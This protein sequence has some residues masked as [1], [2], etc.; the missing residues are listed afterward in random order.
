MNLK[1]GA[2]WSLVTNHQS[3]AKYF[4]KVLKENHSAWSSCTRILDS[5]KINLKEM[6]KSLCC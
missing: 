3:N 2:K 5:E 4:Q 1:H 6:I